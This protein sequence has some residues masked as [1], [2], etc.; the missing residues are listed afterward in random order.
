M[1]TGMSMLI[2]SSDDGPPEPA[3][4]QRGMGFYHAFK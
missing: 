2:L 1:M 3:V 4:E